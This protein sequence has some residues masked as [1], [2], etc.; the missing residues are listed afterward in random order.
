[1]VKVAPD[2]VAAAAPD[3]VADVADKLPVQTTPTIR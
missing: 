2:D 1:M 3:D